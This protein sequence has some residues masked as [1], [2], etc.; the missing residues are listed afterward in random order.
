[1]KIYKFFNTLTK[2]EFCLWILSIA[3]VTISFVF[4]GEGS[5]LTLCAS[6]IGVTAL[7]FVAKGHVVGQVLTVIFSLFY[8]LISYQF[9]YYGEMITYLG[10]TT[11]IA[12]MSVVSWLKHPYKGEKA[13]VEIAHLS[14]KNI[15][16]MIML[17]IVVTFCFYFILAYFDTANLTISTISIATSFLASYLMLFRS[18]AYAMAYGANDIVLIILWVLATSENISFF[19]MI[20]CFIMFLC[21]DIYGFYNWTKM[22]HKQSK[23]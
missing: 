16:I 19:P 20:I 14:K 13:E 4:V 18:S 15:V 3:V 1:M 10:M 8:A 11:P 7:I 12:I 22:K 6:L 9:Q 2:F 21:N 23:N 17:T 5:I